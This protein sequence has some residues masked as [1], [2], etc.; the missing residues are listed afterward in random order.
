MIEVSVAASQVKSSQV[1]GCQVAVKSE[2]VSSPTSS[3]LKSIVKWAEADRV[4]DW[5]VI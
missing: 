1:A 2:S 4:L 3:H 5:A